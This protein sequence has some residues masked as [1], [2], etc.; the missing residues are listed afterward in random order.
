MK[1]K[2]YKFKKGKKIIKVTLSESLK[3]AIRK[4]LDSSSTKKVISQLI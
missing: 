4:I 3:L 2:N 1:L